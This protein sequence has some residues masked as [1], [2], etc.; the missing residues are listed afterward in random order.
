MSQNNSGKIDENTTLTEEKTEETV[1]HS[2]VERSKQSKRLQYKKFAR[3][4]D[5]S[6]VT[7]D[8]LNCILGSKKRFEIAKINE[9]P[10]KNSENDEKSEDLDS[11]RASFSLNQTKT[12]SDTLHKFSTNKMSVSDYFASKMASKLSSFKNN[13]SEPPQAQI[14]VEQLE[15][16]EEVCEIKKKIRRTKKGFG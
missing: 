15:V 12:D 5:L 3:S 1:V 9:E 16:E 6:T 7:S 10:L 11:F 13:N 4:K 8:D 2:L 14:I